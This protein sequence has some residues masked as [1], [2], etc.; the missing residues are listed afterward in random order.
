[1]VKVVGYVWCDRHCEIHVDS[2]NPY[3]YH[4]DDHCQPSEHLAVY[5]RPRKGED[6]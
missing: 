5:R 2:L 1:M 6:K 3:D 4:E